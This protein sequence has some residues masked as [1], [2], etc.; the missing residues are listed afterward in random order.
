MGKNNFEKEMSALK[1][2]L[3]DNLTARKNIRDSLLSKIEKAEGELKALD[4]VEFL[5]VANGS[6]EELDEILLKRDL[7]GRRIEAYKAE[8]SKADSANM[9]ALFRDIYRDSLILDSESEAEAAANIENLLLQ[10]A[11]IIKKREEERS[12]VLFI[13]QQCVNT[14]IVS[15]EKL[16]DMSTT[17]EIMGANGLV[18]NLRNDLQRSGPFRKLSK[19]ALPLPPGV[20]GTP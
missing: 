11:N 15:P 18:L 5:Q 10:V 14:S 12:Q 13:R 1:K 17:F 20:Y 2:R 6:D 3:S 4:G 8:L 19:D 7:I 9:E 16:A